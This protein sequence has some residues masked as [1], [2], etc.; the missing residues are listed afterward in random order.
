M[1][2]NFALVEV[3]INLVA[4]ANEFELFSFL[5][6][7]FLRVSQEEFKPQDVKKPHVYIFDSLNKFLKVLTNELSNS[8]PP[9][10]EIDHKI[11]TVPGSALPSKAPYKLNQKELEEL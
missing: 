3:G 2:N 10:K 4:L 1:W 9:C 8:L 6:L 7:I 11:K 5:I